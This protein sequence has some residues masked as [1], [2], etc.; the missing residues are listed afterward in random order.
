MRRLITGLVLMLAVTVAPAQAGADQ[1]VMFNN[2]IRDGGFNEMASEGAERFSQR[3]GQGV[4]QAVITSADDSVN[5]MEAFIRVGVKHLVL[6]GWVNAPAVRTVAQRHPTV[7]FTLIDAVVEGGNIRS[8]EFAEEEAAFLAGIAAGVVSRGGRIGVVAGMDIPPIQRF[9]C[10]FA[11]GVRH[12][13]PAAQLEALVLGQDPTVFRDREAGVRAAQ[14]LTGR[15]VDVLFAPAGLAGRAALSEAVRAGAAGIGV[16]ANQNA[17]H[18]G[19]IITSAVK[20]VDTAVDRA[21][22]QVAEQQWQAGRYR[23]G[24]AEGGVGWSHDQHNA[25]VIAPALPVITA[26]A[27]A[28]RNG[29]LLA[30]SGPNL[31]EC[32]TTPGSVQPAV[33]DGWPM[34]PSPLAAAP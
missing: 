2:A 10:G 32:V 6:I 17:L 9:V 14:D 13:A 31:M 15:G 1:A 8:I 25:T 20:R 34:P 3:T 33:P 28:M 11:A 22:T 30:P 5:R 24:L 29:L 19:R 26:A 23:L 7:S 21:L 16:D 4:R 12:A 18:P 27:D